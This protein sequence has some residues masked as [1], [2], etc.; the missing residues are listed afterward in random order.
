MLN[1]KFTTEELKEIG[2]KLA[3][4]NQKRERLEDDKKQSQSQYKSDIDAADAE[5]RRLSQKLARGSEDRQ[6]ECD[7]FYN[8]PEEGKKTIIR[9]DT[10]E[11][12]SIDKMTE[13][14][15]QDL[16]INGLGAKK[17][18][19]E[20]VFRDKT[21]CELCTLEE[22]ET[23]K[24][25]ADGAKVKYE[26]LGDGYDEEKLVDAKPDHAGTL[27]VAYEADKETKK[28]VFEVWVFEYAGTDKT[29]KS[30][31]TDRT[32]D[33]KPTAASEKKGAK[34]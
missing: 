18:T 17:E 26:K 12:V 28:D 19:K 34:K 24:K 15:M 23:Y 25:D 8:T 4:E 22:L 11:E 16:I 29:D 31:K 5:I 32:D 13:D 3:L 30:D 6:I 1:C 9:N 21:S 2:I 7:V 10:H 27:I 20:F 14:E 33:A